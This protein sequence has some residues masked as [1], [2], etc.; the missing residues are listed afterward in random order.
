[1]A[2]KADLTFFL[3]ED[4][5]IEITCYKADG[6]TA[7]DLTGG[8]VQ[9][10]LASGAALL[11]DL[12]VGQGV[13]LSGTPTDGMATILLGHAASALLT[14]GDFTY[15]VRAKLADGTISDQAYGTLTVLPSKFV[16]F[17]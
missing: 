4:W 11:A 9:F 10:R 12:K 7:L 16:S 6:V 2:T 8:D 3:G 5:T 17:P 14:S 13:T 1:M 15:E